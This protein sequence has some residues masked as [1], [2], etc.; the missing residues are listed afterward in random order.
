MATDLRTYRLH[1]LCI[2]T[3]HELPA[4]SVQADADVLVVDRAPMSGTYETPPGQVIAEHPDFYQAT[5][6]EHEHTLRYFGWCD[7]RLD[8]ALETLTCEPHDAMPPG[9]DDIL[10]EGS[11]L[12]WALGLRDAPTIHASGV[13]MDG[14]AIAIAGPSNSGKSSVAALACA[15]GGRVITDDVLR[16]SRHERPRCYRGTSEFRIRESV[17][18]LA[19]LPGLSKRLIADGRVGAK[20]VGANEDELPL[21]AIIFPVEAPEVAVNRLGQSQ[22]APA[23]VG[24]ARLLWAP[25]ERQRR[26][27]ADMA[28]LARSVPIVRLHAPWRSII[29]SADY[30]T[31][32]EILMQVR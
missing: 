7:F 15:G 5:T 2:T 16:V 18:H 17:Q 31:A 10:L 1:G 11:V 23:L 28:H 12:A 29:R 14:R 6:S 13:W 20:A 19:D 27:F 26:H 21:A 25:G 32:T 8:A 4:P 9:Y 3:T 30:T 24:L 22:A